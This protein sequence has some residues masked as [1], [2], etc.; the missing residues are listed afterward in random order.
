MNIQEMCNKYVD[1]RVIDILNEKIAEY[2]INS[3]QENFQKVISNCPMGFELTARFTSNY[4]QEKSIRQQRK[5]HK[6]E[7]W[8]FYLNWQE[9]LPNF[10]D[11]IGESK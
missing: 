1:Q 2:N 8:E 10:L 4:L 5:G 7:E 11:L 9:T 6:L 3:I